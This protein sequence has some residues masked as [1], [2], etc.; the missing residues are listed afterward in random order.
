MTSFTPS[1]GDWLTLTPECSPILFECVRKDW[2]RAQQPNLRREAINRTGTHFQGCRQLQ[3][4][5][6]AYLRSRE[7]FL[8]IE[9][10]ICLHNLHLR[11]SNLWRKKPLRTPRSAR[12]DHALFP[13]K[14][15]SASMAFSFRPFLW[16]RLSPTFSTTPEVTQAPPPIDTKVNIST[17]LFKITW[18]DL[19]SSIRGF[20]TTQQLGT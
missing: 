14:S 9:Q 17:E 5:S 10:L 11:V 16:S 6:L 7:N 4:S 3:P 19:W 8:V 20:K 18:K 1:Y 2:E 12:E 13:R 15:A